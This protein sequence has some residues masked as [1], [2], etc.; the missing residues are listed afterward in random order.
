MRARK[1]RDSNRVNV[2]LQSGGGNHFRR[3]P[4]ARVNNFHS[5]VAQSARNNFRAAVMSIKPR[6]GY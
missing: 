1:N 4:Q 3:L 5:G 6:F 2:F